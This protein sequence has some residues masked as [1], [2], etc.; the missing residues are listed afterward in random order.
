[1]LRDELMADFMN[2]AYLAKQAGLPITD[3][4]TEGSPTY[5]LSY[6]CL[7]MARAYMQKYG[8]IVGSAMKAEEGGRKAVDQGLV[9]V[10]EAARGGFKEALLNTKKQREAAKT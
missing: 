8:E 4:G 10:E 6:H 2:T 3:E 1:M 7:H 5:V 9:V